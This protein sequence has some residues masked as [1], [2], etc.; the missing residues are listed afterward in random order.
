MPTD[1]HQLCGDGKRL[2][3]QQ[4]VHVRYRSPANSQELRRVLISIGSKA[5]Q[6]RKLRHGDRWRILAHDEKPDNIKLE[7]EFCFR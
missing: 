6:A 4:A 5:L 3:R 1:V 7:E 2:L